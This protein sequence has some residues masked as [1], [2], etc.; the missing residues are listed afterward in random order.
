MGR[1]IFTRHPMDSRVAY[2][3]QRRDTALRNAALLC[4]GVFV[5][6]LLV[7]AYINSLSF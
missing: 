2:S 1:I 3:A 4:L 6:G 7:L 5:L